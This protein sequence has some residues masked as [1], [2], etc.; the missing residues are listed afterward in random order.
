MNETTHSHTY[1]RRGFLRSTVAASGSLV[2]AARAS[3]ETASFEPGDLRVALIG[4]GT[5]G[6]MLLN[7]AL[8]IPGIKFQAVCDIWENYNLQQAARILTGFQQEHRTYANYQELLANEKGLDAVLIA[9]PDFC[10]AEQ[11]VACLKAGLPVYCEAPM[12]NTLEGAKQMVQAAKE[13]GKLL[14]I[15]FQRRSNPWYRYC[16]EHILNETKLLGLITAANGQWN[17]P[18]QPDR[19]WPKRAPLDEATLKQYG[20]QSMQQFRNWQWYK[21]LGGGPLGELGSHQID[22]FN[23][24]FNRPP[25]SVLA[26]GGTDYYDTKTHEWYDAV[27]SIV[28]YGMEGKTIRALY[29]T[30]SSNSN[31]G[32]FES[33]MGDQGT[34]SLSEVSGRCKVYREPAAPDWD[35]WQKLGILAETK[36]S[37]EQKAKEKEKPKSDA[38]LDVQETVIPP[39]YAFPVQFNDPVH[40]PHLENFFNA[41]RGKENLNCPA[42]TAYVTTVC[43]LKIN[44]AAEKGEKLEFKPEDFQV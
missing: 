7:A 11:T 37:L 36:E 43:V 39:S 22:V 44:E 17:R 30:L 1:D 26:S 28:E 31:Y 33:L 4:A 38:V 2:L 32:Y 15:G 24:F 9:T 34:L 42:E 25:Q 13:T 6:Q 19:G 18:V 10:H 29:Q 20:F 40:K 14:Q 3:G 16:Y 5:Q 12:S 8:K 21:H 41:V 27:M 35:K 23:W